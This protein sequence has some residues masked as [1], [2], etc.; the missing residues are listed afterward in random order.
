MS[1]VSSTN[2]DKSNTALEVSLRHRLS[3]NHQLSISFGLD[4]GKCLGVFGPSGSGK[5]TLLRIISGLTKVTSG[6]IIHRGSVWADQTKGKEQRNRPIAYVPQGA[7]LI[8]NFSVL[9]H[10]QVA[11]KRPWQNMIP[12]LLPRLIDELE[13]SPLLARLPCKLSGGER[14]RVSLSCALLQQAPL[15]LLDEPFSAFDA[16]L[17]IKAQQLVKD[18]QRTLNN[19]LILVSHSLSELS[20]LS[21][22]ALVIDKRGQQSFG[23]LASVLDRVEFDTSSMMQFIQGKVVGFK[24]ARGELSKRRNG[25]WA[26][27]DSKLGRLTVP[28]QD[29]DIGQTCI[30]NLSADSV[31][32]T[33]KGALHSSI[34]SFGGCIE[35][36]EH[37]NDAGLSTLKVRVNGHLIFVRSPSYKL[38]NILVDVGGSVEVHLPQLDIV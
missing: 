23:T 8:P 2:L 33:S 35:S 18:I 16:K 25:V 7:P 13:L 36:I 11:A 27:L 24:D 21:D 30:C 12:D 32:L 31:L 26:V 10:L 34:N 22:M 14:Q 3:D 38:T 1:H 29:L 4:Y 15:L 37:D 20:T 5:T 19:E 6:S 9:E 17:K 28:I